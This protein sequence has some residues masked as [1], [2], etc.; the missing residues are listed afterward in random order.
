MLFLEVKHFDIDLIHLFSR[1]RI[2]ILNGTL[3]L[4]HILHPAIHTYNNVKGI[5]VKGI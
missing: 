5:A 4:A 3:F 1:F 2:D